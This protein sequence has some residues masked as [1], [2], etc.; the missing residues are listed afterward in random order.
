MTVA[1]V[2]SICAIGQS[3]QLGL[4]GMLPWEGDTRRHFQ[5]DVARFFD[6]TKGHVLLAGPVTIAAVPQFAYE[7]RTIAVIRSHEKPEDVLARYPGRIVFIGGGPPVWD[8]YA[9]YIQHWDIMRLPYDGPADRWFNPEWLT[10]GKRRR[11]K[12]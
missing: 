12:A 1:T 4:D 3:G 2:R 11:R 8:V 5:E 10:A 6:I 9:P 7:D